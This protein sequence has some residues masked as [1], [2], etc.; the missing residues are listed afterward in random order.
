VSDLLSQYINQGLSS[1]LYLYLLIVTM[2][3]WPEKQCPQLKAIT[4]HDQ[5]LGLHWK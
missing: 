3:V 5:P 1:E 2:A 4:V